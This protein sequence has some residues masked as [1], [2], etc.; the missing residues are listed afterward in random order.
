MRRRIGRGTTDTPWTSSCFTLFRWTARGIALVQAWLPTAYIH[1]FTDFDRSRLRTMLGLSGGSW[2][3]L[4]VMSWLVAR[5]IV[6]SL[7]GCITVF[8]M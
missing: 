7:D 5:V 4:L 1:G 2:V 3:E 6:L 8:G